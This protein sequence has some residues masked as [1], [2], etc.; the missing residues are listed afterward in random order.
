MFAALASVELGFTD[1]IYQGGQ[2]LVRI[3]GRYIS[4]EKLSALYQNISLRVWLSGNT[5][6]NG[7]KSDLLATLAATFYKSPCQVGKTHEAE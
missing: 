2:A 4:F 7:L 3:G 6:L 5:I 1:I